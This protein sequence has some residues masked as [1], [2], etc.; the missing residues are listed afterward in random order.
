M[1]LPPEIQQNLNLFNLNQKLKQ[2]RGEFSL[3]V[4]KV[5]TGTFGI[6]KTMQNIRD[7]LRDTINALISGIEA[8]VIPKDRF[9]D[10]QNKDATLDDF[11]SFDMLTYYNGLKKLRFE[12]HGIDVALLSVQEVPQQPLRPSATIEGVLD[13]L[14]SNEFIEQGYANPVTETERTF[15]YYVIE[16]GDTLKLIAVK[17][18]SGDS[19]RYTLVAKENNLK[20]SDLID[21]NL[22]GTVIKIPLPTEP[23][24]SGASG[25]LVYEPLF[26]G[27]SQ[28]EINRFTYGRDIAL[29]SNN[30]SQSGNILAD[31]SG[32]ILV[33]TGIDGVINNIEDR[34]A[35][36]KM[37]LNAAHPDWGLLPLNQDSGQVPFLIMLDRLLDDMEG[38]ASSDPR[39]VSATINRRKID[40]RGDRL[41]VS[42]DIFLIGGQKSNNNF[43]LPKNL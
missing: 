19:G 37:S 38:Q 42:M 24:A 11:A 4:N 21:T 13:T 9:T 29:F 12:L 6:K 30:P 34:F 36:T 25:N 10:F 7:T 23:G 35:N 31:S 2:E 27:T 28:A 1:T 5:Q 16:K 3:A 8:V 41:D 39:V 26:K 15:K 14:D 18:Y 33:V 22:V 32:D 43:P 40:I 17:N 20:E